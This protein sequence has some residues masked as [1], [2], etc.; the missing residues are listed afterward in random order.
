MPP[1][2]DLFAPND[3]V[4]VVFAD[5]EGSGVWAFESVARTGWIFDV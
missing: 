3:L 4:D 5:A 1:V 2:R